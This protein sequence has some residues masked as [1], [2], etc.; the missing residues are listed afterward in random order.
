[1]E[2]QYWRRMGSWR[3]DIGGEW[4]VG[5]EILEENGE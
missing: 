2:G 5:G 1:L 3:G 4:G